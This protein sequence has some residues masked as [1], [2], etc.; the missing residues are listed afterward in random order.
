M[1]GAI[2]EP[3]AVG[4]ALRLHNADRL[5]DLLVGRDARLA[6]VVEPAKDVIMPSVGE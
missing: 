1:M 4:A 6:Q 3:A 2:E 5:G